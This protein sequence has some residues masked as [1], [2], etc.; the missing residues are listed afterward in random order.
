MATNASE[1]FS[2][3]FYEERKSLCLYPCTY[4]EIR[5]T[6]SMKSKDNYQTQGST[7]TLNFNKFVTV[8]NTY[9]SYTELELLAELGGYIGLFLGVSV[10]S[11]SDLIKNIV[12]F[13]FP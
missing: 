12:D 8:S 3:L 7:L 10:S 5:K 2:E 9:Y 13:I 1:M 6:D 4:L 11:L